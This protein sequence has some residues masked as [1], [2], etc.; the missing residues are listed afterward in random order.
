MIVLIKI[1]PILETIV[2]TSPRAGPEEEVLVN[3]GHDDNGRL[4][5]VSTKTCGIVFAHMLPCT[6]GLSECNI[7]HS[8]VD[9][10]DGSFSWK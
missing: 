6:E 7:A 2:V 8:A 4:L 3:K 9:T 10:S 1:P 5:S